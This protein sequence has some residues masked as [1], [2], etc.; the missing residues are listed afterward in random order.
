MPSHMESSI[1]AAMVASH[2]RWLMPSP[3]MAAWS[4]SQAD[5]SPD[6]AFSMAGWGVAEDERNRERRRGSGERASHDD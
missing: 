4:C 6:M 1:G 5:V 3:L 2:G